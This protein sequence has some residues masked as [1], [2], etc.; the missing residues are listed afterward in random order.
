[1]AN[2]TTAIDRLVSSL[3]DRLQCELLTYRPASPSSVRAGPQRYLFPTGPFA[4]GICHPGDQIHLVCLT[5]NSPNIFWE[6]IAEK[7]DR[8]DL[9]K[10]DCVISRL[11]DEATV[12]LRYCS[13]P[14][15]FDLATVEAYGFPKY[16]E[17]PYVPNPVRQNL[18]LLHDTR[19]LLDRLQEVLDSFRHDY[20]AL[21]RWAEAAGIFSKAFGTLDAESL[22][23]LLFNA[24]AA[25]AESSVEIQSTFSASIQSFANQ[26]SA[27]NMCT[28]SKRRTYDPPMYLAASSRAT[29]E[30]EINQLFQNPDL[31]SFSQ[32]Q[33]YQRFCNSF[34]TFI[35]VSA[36]CW[37][38]DRQRGT[39]SSRLIHEILNLARHLQDVGIE[40]KHFRFWPHAF[41]PSEDE[42]LYVIGFNRP[43][44]D[45]PSPCF[46]TFPTLK[47]ALQEFI[48]NLHIDLD[49]TLGMATLSICSNEEALA[50]LSKH[51]LPGPSPTDLC[52]TC[53]SPPPPSSPPAS[54]SNSSK[55]F[56]PASQVISRLRWD[57]AHTPFEYE[58]G[59]LD[60]FE[61]L[62]WLP[63]EQWG[64]ATEEEDFI[65][66]HRIRVFRTVGKGDERVVVWNR[67]ERVCELDG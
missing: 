31:I 7:L 10:H 44:P 52:P 55:K 65:P 12:W 18:A 4:L 51:V 49:S 29:I 32:E 14:P 33:H 40:P 59:Y 35:L 64:K 66:E 13:I 47:A 21:R 67:E 6:Y 61:G 15:H 39:F 26:H 41:K 38:V 3:T 54:T 48:S 60:R 50:L 56:P 1:M 28:P 36:E 43:Q 63:L 9:P 24:K 2:G 30:S 23:W 53:R 11:G 17:S 19:Y 45:Y 8:E 20:N 16:P 42:W 27:R 58:V 34:H 46:T 57:P 22:V 62:M 5:D 25:T 37:V